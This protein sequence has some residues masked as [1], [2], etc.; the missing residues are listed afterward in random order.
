MLKVLHF[1][2]HG[3]K[4]NTRLT[5]FHNPPKKKTV[6]GRHCQSDIGGPGGSNQTRRPQSHDAKCDWLTQYQITPKVSSDVKLEAEP[7][8]LCKGRRVRLG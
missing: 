2:N 7:R 5:R 6:R 1:S 8:G 4:N 3:L